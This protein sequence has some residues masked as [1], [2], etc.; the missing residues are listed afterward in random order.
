M[1]PVFDPIVLN[2]QPLEVVKSVKLLG[3]K[4]TNNLS[5]NEHIN[6]TIKKASKRFYF[7]IQL[8]RA[9]APLKDLVLFYI[10]CIRSVLTY[11]VRCSLMGCQIT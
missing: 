9:N 8:K 7:F 10:T 1:N 3:V 5:W 2:G 6:D 11:A 4:L